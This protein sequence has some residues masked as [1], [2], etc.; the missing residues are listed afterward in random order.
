M[1]FTYAVWLRTAPDAQLQERR[2]VRAFYIGQHRQDDKKPGDR[3]SDWLKAVEEE[4]KARLGEAHE[5]WRRSTV[6]SGNVRSDRI[7]FA[8]IYRVSDIMGWWPEDI[9][10][11]TPVPQDPEIRRRLGKWVGWEVDNKVFG[12]TFQIPDDVVTV[13]TL[14]AHLRNLLISDQHHVL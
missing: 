9:T 14:T 13:G 2:E 12:E 7:R 6:G 10:C 3:L 11:Q 8:V 4:E 5:V 1:K